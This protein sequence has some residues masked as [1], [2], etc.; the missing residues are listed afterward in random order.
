MDRMRENIQ[1]VQK[2][3]VQERENII[4][5]LENEMLKFERSLPPKTDET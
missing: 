4:L 3:E 2:S 1:H 5:Q